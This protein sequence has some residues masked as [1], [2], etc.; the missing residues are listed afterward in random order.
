MILLN[1]NELIHKDFS[2]KSLIV[3]V[4]FGFYCSEFR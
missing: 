4:K 2:R 1:K 3:L